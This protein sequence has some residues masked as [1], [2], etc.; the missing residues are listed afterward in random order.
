MRFDGWPGI[1][2]I[3]DRV[4]FHGIMG[5]WDDGPMEWIPEGRSRNWPFGAAGSD[6]GEVGI[7]YNVHVIGGELRVRS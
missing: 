6:S 2:S 7:N 4:G 1:C 3:V 5:P